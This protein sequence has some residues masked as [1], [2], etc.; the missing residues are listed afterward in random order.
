MI[1]D[2]AELYTA[3]D[4]FFGD[5][6]RYCQIC[7]YDD[8]AGYQWLLP[9]EVEELLNADIELLK[10]NGEINIINPFQGR[11]IN[12]EEVKPQCPYYQGKR[13]SIRPLRP[14]ICR[15]YPLNFAT[16]G[17]KIYLV[18]HLDCDYSRCRQADIYFHQ[19]AIDLFRQ[20]EPRFFKSILSV[21]CKMDAITKFPEGPNKYLKLIDVED[22]HSHI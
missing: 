5:I 15:I 4:D 12:I 14:F 22:I 19:Q 6:S 8:C 11:A 20:I 2:L 7:K 1:T 13:C 16:E 21:Y 3:C 18:L 17:G 9:D 10:I